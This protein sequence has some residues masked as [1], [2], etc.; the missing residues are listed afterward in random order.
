MLTPKDRLQK[1]LAQEEIDRPPC[2]CPGGMMNMITRELMEKAGVGWPEAHRD[3]S[4]MAKLA[5]AVYEEKCFEN[6]GVPFCMT[7][8][9]EHMGAKVDLGTDVYEPHV[10]GYAIDSVSAWE[11]LSP[12]DFSRGRAKVVLD[13]I[14]ILKAKGTKVP[15]V[16][17]LTGPISVASSLMEPVTYY[18]ELRKKKEDARRFM[19]F[20]TAQLILFGRKQLEAGADV[21]AISDPSG[22]GEI[23]GPRL[24]AEYAVPA[25]NQVLASLTQ[26][27]KGVG[28]IVHICGKMHNVY[29]EMA[30][31]TSNALSFDSIV[32]IKNARENLPGRT[33]MGNVST[34]ALEFAQPAKVAALTKKCIMDGVGIISPACGLG[35]K[36]PLSNI[37]TML[38]TVQ[39]KDYW[40]NV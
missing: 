34:Y 10:V 26:E 13:A 28:T 37:R 17:N 24:F 23:L 8:E 21:I 2:I 29:G 18:K 5:A 9:A 25:I 6:Y 19:E 20:V 32:N 12:I 7:I 16:G 27:K 30:H 1:A 11:Q 38:G 31:I 15:V 22:T 36:S 14:K 33:L 3:A 40:E 35:T 39:G 4:L